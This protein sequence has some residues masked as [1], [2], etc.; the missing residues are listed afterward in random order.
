MTDGTISGGPRVLGGRYELG[1][2]LGRGGMAE[3]H[4]GRDTR[5]GR[6]VA[7]KLLRSDL[8]RDPSFQSRFRREAQSAASLNHPN[9]VAVYDT[10]EE[11]LPDGAGVGPYIVMEYV[12]GETLRD[13]LRS[14]RR[15]LPER[16]LEITEGLLAALDYSHRHGIIHRDVKPGN[17]M[18]TTSGQVKVMD[19]G[20]ARAVADSAATM[21]AT[22][23]VLGTAQYLSPEQARGE[24]VDSRSDVYSA[25]CLLYELLTGRPPFT[26]DSPVSVAYQHVREYAVPPSQLD[27]DIP[28]SYDAVVMKALAKDPAER[29][30]T[31]ADMAADLE[32]ARTG[33]PVHAAATGAAAT[34]TT[35]PVPGLGVETTQRLPPVAPVA[36]TPQE[37]PPPRRRVGWYVVL[38]IATLAVLVGAAWL[39]ATFFGGGNGNKV[40]VPD[41]SGLT[42]ASAQSALEKAGLT[43]DP[44]IA[45]K[46]SDK[47]K[48]T[49]I[50]QDP[51]AGDEAAKASA[52]SITVS[53]GPANV[54]VPVLVGLTQPQ[55]EQ[56]LLDV[57][58]KRGKVT[59][60]NDSTQPQGVVID[61]NPTT[62]TSVAPGTPVDLKVSSGLITVP[63]DL[64]GQTVDAAI[65]ELTNAGFQTK[66]QPQV[67]GSVPAGQVLATNPAGGT[68]LAKGK[69]VQVIYAVAPSSSPPPASSSPPPSGSAS[70]SPTK[71]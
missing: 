67:N 6:T 11:P 44:N 7:I 2:L 26:G 5:L 47:P 18:L 14:G 46:T 1:E 21:T 16:A 52:V 42:K 20:I 56:A 35:A 40:T 30:A 37:G 27:A 69:T 13:V 9:I 54:A 66:R 8:A 57:G 71:S 65:V 29:Y 43:L 49:V 59:L 48:G 63:D 24:T 58:L 3:V 32:R 36:V 34:A 55:A 61:S 50:D 25:G 60:V 41:L 45:T 33:Q 4:V 10:G 70:P 12:H 23:G 39:A 51:A 64:V 31:A 15:L 28:P 53:G 38:G 62:G 17:V 68:E 22:S 19:F